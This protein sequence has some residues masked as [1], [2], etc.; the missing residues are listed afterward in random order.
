MVNNCYAI[1]VGFNIIVLLYFG[2]NYSI[3]LVLESFGE[4]E[5]NVMDLYS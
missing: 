2:S 5:R 3:G 4:F 1:I